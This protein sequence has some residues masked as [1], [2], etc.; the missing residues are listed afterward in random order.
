MEYFN[1]MTSNKFSLDPN[2]EFIFIGKIIGLRTH[3]DLIQ[4]FIGGQDNKVY[5]WNIESGELVHTVGPFSTPIK[6]LVFRQGWIHDRVRV[7]GFWTF[8]NGRV[9]LY[10]VCNVNM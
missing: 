9:E 10:G 2:E 5:I 8:L 4:N 7:P 3:L 1:Q 6:S